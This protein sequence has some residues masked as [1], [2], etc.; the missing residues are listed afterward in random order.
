[1]KIPETELKILKSGKLSL[2]EYLAIDRNKL[3][4][5]RTLLMYIR[6]GLYLIVFGLSI[7]KLEA[8][9]GMY[10]WMYVFFGL[11]LLS[12]LIGI[13]QYYKINKVLNSIN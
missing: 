11:G 1:M 12:I 3:A 5:Q 4:N 8:L 7:Y 6:T 13:V 10:N 9:K 2:L